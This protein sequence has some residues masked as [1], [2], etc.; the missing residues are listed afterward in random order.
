MWALQSSRLLILQT[1]KYRLLIHDV[2]ARSLQEK[3]S[4]GMMV[5]VSLYPFPLLTTYLTND[6][7]VF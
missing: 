4:R 5:H 3:G 7:I 6:E 1:T 2:T